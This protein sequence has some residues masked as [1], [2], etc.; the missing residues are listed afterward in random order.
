MS[1]IDLSP[2]IRIGL[3]ADTHLGFDDPEHP[4][5]QRRRRGDDFFRNFQQILDECLTQ[6][7]HVL[8]HGGD[9]FYRSR[10]PE[11]LSAR[12]YERLLPLAEAGIQI[13]LVPGNH[14]R[15]KL[16]ASPLFHHPNVLVFD[17]PRTTVLALE[18]LE[19]AFGG[20]PFL[21][22]IGGRSFPAALAATELMETSADL[23]ILCMHQAVDGAVV[24]PRHFMFRKGREVIGRDQFPAVV[25]LVLSGHIHRR[26]TL[27]TADGR[28]IVYPGSIERTSIAEWEETKG[29]AFIE[30]DP[31]LE[32]DSCISVKFRD[33]YAR[34]MIPVQVPLE[35]MEAKDIREFLQSQ[36][37]SWPLDAVV[38]VRLDHQEQRHLLSNA[39]LR[40]WFPYSMNVDLSIPRQSG[41]GRYRRTD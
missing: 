30:I 5:V 10:I 40:S 24:G 34:P 32:W 26:Q 17:R 22:S 11:S 7:V 35:L 13:L 14:E 36:S 20:F 9:V 3:L 2:I 41:H 15:S 12:V 27:Q 21:R 28:L 4:R 33:L 37:V 6:E 19:V 8:V 29:Y 23:K 38:R 39:D 1:S 18:G 25:D 31:A 16:P